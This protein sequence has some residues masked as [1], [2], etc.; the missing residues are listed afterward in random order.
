MFPLNQSNDHSNVYLLYIYIFNP[1]NIYIY[2]YIHSINPCHT[3]IYRC[4]YIYIIYL[5]PSPHKLLSSI[6]VSTNEYLA[7]GCSDPNVNATLW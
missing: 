6:L 5:I 4:V 1:R 2:I 3:F 7:S